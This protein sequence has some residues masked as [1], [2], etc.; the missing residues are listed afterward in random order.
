MFGH[1]NVFVNQYKQRVVSNPCHLS[2][3]ICLVKDAFSS[4]KIG[5]GNDKDGNDSINFILFCNV[6]GRLTCD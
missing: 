2:M 5:R 4:R 1:K 6:L 3:Y